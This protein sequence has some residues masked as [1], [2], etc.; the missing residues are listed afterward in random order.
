MVLEQEIPSYSVWFPEALRNFG[1]AAFFVV[2]GT[3]VISYLVAAFR[4]GPMPA[5]DRLY[6]ALV[7]AA[8]DLV[9]I[10][11]RRIWALARLAI[12]EAFRRR[13]WVALV[14]FAIILMFAGWFLDPSTPDPGPLYL[15]FVLSWT[16]YLTV[17]LALFIS[18]FSLPADIKNKT[19]TTVV[20]KPV[21]G[22]EIVLG[23]IL[24]F[25]LIG[26]A[27]LAVMGACSYVFVVR[28]LNHTHVLESTDLNEAALKPGALKPGK[29]GTTRDAQNHRH[30]VYLNADGTME[31]EFKHGH[32]HI[33]TTETIDGK[34]RYIVGPPVDLLVARVPIRGHLRFLDRDGSPKE[35]GINV[36][37]EWEYRGFVDGNTKSAAIWTFDN[38]DENTLFSPDTPPEKRGLPLE[39]TIR[40]FRTYK[41]NIEKGIT[42]KL[43]FRN[44]QTQLA[45]EPIIFTAKEFAVDRRF[46]SRDM[47]RAVS[48]DS[49]QNQKIDLFKDLVAN[50]RLEIV[51]QCLEPGQLLGARRPTYIF[52]PTMLRSS[53]I[54]SKATLAFGCKWCWSSAWA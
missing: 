2:L 7:G 51:L 38:I 22:A 37:K 30:D 3:L 39:M 32:R 44:P 20:T 31:T 43:F 35:K 54:S 25:T 52:G 19:I 34:T 13:V 12:Q 27:L 18:T 36:G 50:G 45:S 11:P 48:P 40:V 24:G 28:S 23:R 8:V 15:S 4:Y 14:A 42:G 41:G 47:H 10:S 49:D 17:L 1:E 33:V 46:V 21:R 5:G 29:I 53:S 26:T 16:T 6:R 9:Q